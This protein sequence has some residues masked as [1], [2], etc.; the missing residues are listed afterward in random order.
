MT[1]KV[2]GP[3]VICVK[4][5][6]TDEGVE[7]QALRGDDGE[8]YTLVGD[9]KSFHNG[10]RVVV[11]GT[12]VEISFCMQGTTLAVSWIGAE[13][14]V[15]NK[16]A[17]MRTAPRFFEGAPIIIGGGGSVGI[18][19]N[20]VIHYKPTGRPNEFAHATDD[21]HAGYLVKG[22]VPEDLTPN[23]AQKNVTLTVSC[24][25]VTGLDSPIIIDSRPGGPLKIRFRVSDYPFNTAKNQ[26][27]SPDRTL[28][29]I[30][31]KNNDLPN[32]PQVL[33]A[34]P[35]GRVEI[36]NSLPL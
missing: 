15:V 21:I 20:S 27:F 19:F 16:M 1:N 31:I 30:Q 32:P 18:F 22:I 10:D 12:I 2:N 13:S 7:C 35:A 9:L 4:G 33:L 3:T 24:E 6:L 28:K 36:I 5:I 34:D 8:L 23:L 26:F 11:C 17:A 29:S 14:H 25:D